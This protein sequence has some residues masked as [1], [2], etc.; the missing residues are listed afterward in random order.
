MAVVHNKYRAQHVV[1]ELG[2]YLEVILATIK[3]FIGFVNKAKQ[4]KT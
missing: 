3:V 2:L 1:Q 4:N